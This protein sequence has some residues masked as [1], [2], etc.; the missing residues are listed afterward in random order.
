MYNQYI[1]LDFQKITIWTHA[2]SAL[3]QGSP[4]AGDYEEKVTIHRS[5]DTKTETSQ[6]AVELYSW[7]YVKKCLLSA[8]QIKDSAQV[9]LYKLM[10]S[11]GLL[12]RAQIFKGQ[13]MVNHAMKV[14]HFS[15]LFISYIILHVYEEWT[16][17]RSYEGLWF[18]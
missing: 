14:S 7:G 6:L 12:I 3:A 1:F 8:D 18:S 17:Q 15:Q 4:E 16:S 5:Q 9:Y 13:F 11:S 10:T 2:H